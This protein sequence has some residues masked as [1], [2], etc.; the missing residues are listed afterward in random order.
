MIDWTV[1]NSYTLFAS[2]TAEVISSV[3]I[4]EFGKSKEWTS[5]ISE[6]TPRFFS[7]AR[8]L[9]AVYSSQWEWLAP[10]FHTG[11]RA[12][13][14]ARK[15]IPRLLLPIYTERLAGMISSKGKAN[16][17]PNDALQ[18]LLNAHKKQKGTGMTLEGMTNEQLFLA[19]ASIHA[20]SYTATNIVY[21]LLVYP[22][23]IEELRTE[24]EQGW[25]QNGQWTK[26]SLA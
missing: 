11:T 20:T 24:I 5:L 3:F 4:A 10:W 26:K 9:N 12:M 2:V 16:E 13:W 1:I 18:W 17:Q 7:T 15:N 21:D 8:A 22:E 6:I 14:A 25:A 23:Y 19:I